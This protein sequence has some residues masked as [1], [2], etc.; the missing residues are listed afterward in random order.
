MNIMEKA[1]GRVMLRYPFFGFMLISATFIADDKIGTAATDGVVILYS[2]KFIDTLTMDVA[3]FVIAHE[4]CHIIF[5][6][7]GRRKGRDPAR[8]NDACDYAINIMLKDYGFTLWSECLLNEK[9]RGWSP[10]RI[11]DDLE[12]QGDKAPKNPMSGD[13]KPRPM[14]PEEQDA[15]SRKVRSMVAKANVIARAAGKLPGSLEK[16]I[17][18]IIDPKVPWEEILRDKATRVV[19]E[20]ENW[21]RPNRRIRNFKLPSLG[22]LRIGEYIAIGDTS[23]SFTAEDYKKAAG[24]IQAARDA[25]NPSRIRVI[26]GDTKVQ[27]EE[28]FEQGDPLIFHPKGG[29]GTD[30]RVMLKHAEQFEPAFVVLFTDG[31]TPWPEV[32]PPYPLVVCC[33]TDLPV[34]VGEVIRV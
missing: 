9:Y 7:V 27:R 15:V 10:E 5:D 22:G 20:E 3:A 32:E 4:L 31:G 13:M 18:D 23:G 26:W 1:R 25:V 33:S 6:H 30:M 11:Y 2:P 17:T 16:A 8:W 29:G 14:T 24:A 34:P 21:N 12:R 19:H 28:V